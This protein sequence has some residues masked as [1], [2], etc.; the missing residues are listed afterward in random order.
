MVAVLFHLAGQPD[1]LRRR[2]QR[3]LLDLL[4]RVDL[5]VQWGLFRQGG[6]LVRLVLFLRAGLQAQ[7]RPLRLPDR[8]D[9]EVL[10]LPDLR[11]DLVGLRAPFLQPVRFLP[12]GPVD[13]K[14]LPHR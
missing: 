9:Q 5:L 10:P 14:D 7:W 6:R 11:Q 8:R 2:R 1:L 13:P 4:H 12:V 3:G